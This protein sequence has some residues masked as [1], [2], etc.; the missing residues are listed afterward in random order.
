MPQ[1]N[2]SGLFKNLDIDSLK[3][4]ALKWAEYYNSDKI[5]DD[6]SEEELDSIVRIQRI[7]LFK[8]SLEVDSRVK[9]VLIFELPTFK[10]EDSPWW[11]EKLPGLIDNH[12][13]SLL[14]DETFFN[15]VYI[16]QPA[17]DPKEEWLFKSTSPGD[18]AY[19]S[20]VVTE[21]K[22]ILYPKDE[23]SA[24]RSEKNSFTLL[25]DIWLVT[26]SIN[27]NCA[28]NTVKG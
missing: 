15:E 2:I 24:G 28:N 18:M 21:P 3:D 12:G 22:E 4:Y 17:G 5:L 6:S 25:G 8:P 20:L 10:E 16:K 19:T 1:K 23:I 26:E 9:Y 14:T 13:I 27:L 11:Y 7:V